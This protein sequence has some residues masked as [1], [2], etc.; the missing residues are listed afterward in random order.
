VAAVLLAGGLLAAPVVAHAQSTVAESKTS[1]AS[2]P[3][4]IEQGHIQFRQWC[5]HCHGRDAKGGAKGPDLSRP[6][7]HGE[8]DARLRD[9][10]LQGLPGTQMPA[11]DL[12]EQEVVQIMTFVRSLAPSPAGAV[13]GDVKAGERLFWGD[14]KC[15]TC[16]MVG[17]RGGR[18]GPDLSRVGVARPSG[19][20]AESIREPSRHLTERMAPVDFGTTPIRYTLVSV[21][22]KAG[23]EVTGLLV[24][25]DTFTIILMDANEDLHSYGKKDLQALRYS[26][27]SLMPAYDEQAL[28]AEQLRDLLAYLDGLRGQ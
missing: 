11:N 5:A 21:T 9:T 23:D 12:S 22:P 25:E 16:H 13:A 20:L 7:R 24:T 8:T 6:L 3:A 1:L 15:S 2:D 14:A 26:K 28:S 18:R 4:L 19:F 17:G 27:T 10:I